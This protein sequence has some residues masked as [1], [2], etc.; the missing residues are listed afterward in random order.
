VHEVLLRYRQGHPSMY[1]YLRVHIDRELG[2]AFPGLD[3]AAK[4]LRKAKKT[5]MVLRDQAQARGYLYFER[6]SSGRFHPGHY[7]PRIPDYDEQSVIVSHAKQL[8][9]PSIVSH[10]GT[11]AKLS[12]VSKSSSFVSKNGSFVSTSGNQNLEP[13]TKERAKRGAR[14]KRAHACPPSRTDGHTRPSSAV[15]QAQQVIQEILAAAACTL[16]TF[17]A[18]PSDQ[19]SKLKRQWRLDPAKARLSPEFMA[20]KAATITPASLQ[21]KGL[22]Q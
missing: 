22:R 4:D 16:E 11:I 7:W 9:Q 17:A 10:K 1:A 8:S 3:R 14:N 18:Q 15:E 5:I 21:Q 6:G 13:I 12:M 20:L 19:Q 2:Y